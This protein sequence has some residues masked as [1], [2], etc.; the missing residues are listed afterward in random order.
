MEGNYLTPEEEKHG[1]RD[2][3][4]LPDI[5]KDEV[6]ERV[7]QPILWESRTTTTPCPTVRIILVN[8]SKKFN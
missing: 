5:V 1:H 3:L 7:C 4:G 6:E 2:I 8:V